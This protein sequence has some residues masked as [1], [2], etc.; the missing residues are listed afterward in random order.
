M[1]YRNRL[2]YYIRFVCILC[3]LQI[4]VFGQKQKVSNFSSTDSIQFW[5]I[6]KEAN[7]ILY[8]NPDSANFILKRAAKFTRT[9]QN[10]RLKAFF[11]MFSGLVYQVKNEVT[12][13]YPIFNQS[14][15][16][17]SS[18]G[19]KYYCNV[20]LTNIGVC[21]MIMGHYSPAKENLIHA[22]KYFESVN[23]SD[24]ITAACVNL[25]FIP[26]DLK[27]DLEFENY[28]KK[29]LA[30][31]Q[32]DQKKGK[33]Y[34]NLGELYARKKLINRALEFYRKAFYYCDKAGDWLMVSMIYHNTGRIYLQQHKR[35]SAMCYFQKVISCEKTSPD[36]YLLAM[37]YRDM[38]TLEN[39]LGSQ[40]K[41]WQ[42]I[43]KSLSL[44]QNDRMAKIMAD[45]YIWLSDWYSS[46]HNFE[47]AYL[48][49]L[50]ATVINDSLF[51]ETKT[52]QTKEIE[53]IYQTEKKQTEINLLSEQNK[54]SNLQLR[55]NHIFIL[56]LL[57]LSL[58]IIGISLLILRQ[59]KLKT[60]NKSLELE[61]KLLRLQMNPH[62]I[63][64]ALTAIQNQVLQKPSIE[65][66]SYLSGFA[67][68]MRSILYSS[69]SETISLLQEV[70]TLT[71]YLKLQKLRL[72]DRLNFEFFYQLTSDISEIAIPPMLLQ[73]F[74]ENA[75]EHGIAAK[76]VA[77]G[78]IW[79]SIVEG[80]D[81]LTISIEDDGVGLHQTPG[82]M[83]SE[84]KS[85][86]TKIT[87]E[88]L[89]ALSKTFKTKL[90]FSI[91]NR[92]SSEGK[93]LGSKVFLQLP[94]IFVSN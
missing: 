17:F 66:A 3:L 90:F 39:E 75:I 49:K 57:L 68:L 29:G 93:I 21:Y 24:R 7:A 20:L 73:P 77:E 74:I 63:F 56:F 76:D 53:A 1:L 37:V 18:A 40:D 43:N 60:D 89:L 65:A 79:I 55:N 22:L 83:Q 12:K 9:P 44:A 47:K 94:L 10:I 32:T 84:H 81:K 54:V 91:N 14:F 64:N 61:H 69:R 38:A 58:L 92:V 5:A 2:L 31:A 35:D 80:K 41:A 82:N 88:R 86:A 67:R 70:E 42:Y 4:N 30:Y 26:F 48:Y 27:E 8:Q 45:D 15:Q 33:I 19:D 46:N 51:N 28:L 13:A 59:N 36:N 11:L 78:N 50:K 16:I 23:D 6:V 72:S 85:L 25:S 52:R 71:E 34:N 87:E 62:F